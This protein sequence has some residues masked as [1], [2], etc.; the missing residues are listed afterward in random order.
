[1][2]RVQRS[3]E[4]VCVPQGARVCEL[5]AY[6]QSEAPMMLITVGLAGEF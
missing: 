4:K 3:A 1:M 5:P 6:G 2:Q